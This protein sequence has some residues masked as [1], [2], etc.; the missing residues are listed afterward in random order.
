M[1]AL[2]PELFL[3]RARR[4]PEAPAVRSGSRVVTYRE[5]ESAARRVAGA[6][7]AHGVRAESTV[8]IHVPPGPDLVAALLGTWL[9]GG[10]YV[11]LDPMAPAAR[12]R[13]V[14]DLAGA[15]IVLTTA[16]GAPREPLG[17]AVVWDVA[18]PAG[19][20]RPLP[21]AAPDR[22]A[23]M[24]FTSGSTGRPKG[25]VV[26]HAGIAN[27]VRW[28]V[29]AL[30]LSDADRVLQKTP[31]AFDAA[32][33]EIF[34]P[35]LCGAAVTFGRPDAGRDAAELVRSIREQGATVLQVVPT[36]LRLLANEP[37]L[38]SC[39]SL[40]LICCA[41]EPLHAELCQ[42]VLGQLD[43]QILNTYG[44]TECSIDALAG[45]FDRA[46]D[47]GP[48]PIGRPIDGARA[49]LL[50]PDP[51]V[52]DDPAPRELYLGGVGVARG[53]HGEAALTAERFLPDPEGPPGARLYRTG[54]LVRPRPDGTLE[55]VSRADDQVKLNGVRIEPAEVEAA[56]AAHPEVTE[57]AVRVVTDGRGTPQLAA[58]VVTGRE[59][60]VD[61]LADHLRR[62]LPPAMVPALFTRL[63]ALPRTVSGKTDRARLPEP[64]R[65]GPANGAAG[66][67]VPASTETRIVL[68][69][70]R[71]LLAVDDI[72]PDDDFYRLGGH[73]LLM[74]RLAADLREATGL[75]LDFRD[76][77]R[78][79]TVRAQARLLREAEQAQPIE[80]LPPG[81]RLPLSPA[82]ERFWVLDR[83][84]PASPEYLLPIL[85]WLPAGVP[86]EVVERALALVMGCHDVLR[87]RYVMDADGLAAIVE[88]DPG[89][90]LRVE[91]VSPSGIGK[92]V[93]AELAEGFDLAVAPLFRATLVHDGGPEQLLVLVCHHIVCDGWSARLLDR[94]IAETVAALAAGRTPTLQRPALRY[95]DAVAWLRA[96]PAAE[97]ADDLAYWRETLDGLPPLEL[98]T[99][100][101][102]PARRS[103]DGA[104]IAFELPASVVDGLLAAG[105]D[106][107]ATPYVAF[108][109]LWTVLLGRAGGGWDFGVGVPHAGRSRPELHELVGPF[110][111]TVVIRSRLAP[112]LPFAEALARV[113][114]A[115]REGFAR[116]GAPFE[117]VADAVAGPRDLSR[118]P[119][120]Q[121]QFTMAGDGLAGPHRRERDVAVLSEA[122]TA[123]RTDL[124][125]TLWPYPDGRYGGA[126]EYAATVYARGTVEALVAGFGALAARFA[127]EPALA[128]NVADAPPP[129]ARHEQVILGFARDL[130]KRDD[131]APDDDVFACGGTSLLAARLLWNVQSAFGVEVPLRAFFDRPTVAGLAGEVERLVRAEFDGQ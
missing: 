73:S 18:R 107:G 35:L 70:W 54:D 26:E 123:A 46:Q 103:L 52:S 87:T 47:S 51:G 6:L 104:A 75:A 96:R 99:A 20:D 24:I 117:I 12:L 25:V 37:D 121:T 67:G 128:L 130:L 115:C 111:E 92:A 114:R 64:D 129:A 91:R 33:W 31:L 72:G 19:G 108:L 101:E 127:A 53:Y 80:P 116:H 77:H 36:M 21:S 23:Y 105:R 5:L 93:A 74:T 122:P 7:A 42:R 48:V 56:L 32:G 49:V 34:A 110:I 98:P 94:Q 2:L 118:T 60:T 50:P 17:H 16:G 97:L 131:I 13:E 14:L 43:V 27:R 84:N 90:P 124:A 112:E 4:D 86:P 61:G 65:T 59:S 45:W 66:E 79:T 88:S 1:P 58:W 82:Q 78:A 44:P 55:F 85:T 62:R 9:A 40:R 106:A 68:S 89:V 57:A 41:G 71:R 39:R 3:D 109:T 29:R 113:E 119:L 15:R 83:M 22:A 95:P 125:L 69:V 100:H 28:G 11:P 38:A 76:L 63:D 8:G 81:A 10:C 126:I 120:F 102:R 30:G